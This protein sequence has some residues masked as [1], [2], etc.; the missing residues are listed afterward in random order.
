MPKIN[1][2]GMMVQ[3]TDQ[4]DH[5]IH[6]YVKQTDNTAHQPEVY[7]DRTGLF[8]EELERGNVSLKLTKVRVTDAG[9]YKCSVTS[10]TWPSDAFIKFQVIGIG[11]PPLVSLAAPHGG[12]R[13]TCVSGGWYPCPVL[14]WLDENGADLTNS[15]QTTQENDT[16]N[17]FTVI[18]HLDISSHSGYHACILRPS[19]ANTQ[20]ESKIQVSG[21]C[22][23]IPSIKKVIEPSAY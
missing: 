13:F 7:R 5:E 10:M 17:L 3:W 16:N 18:S 6:N 23:T 9:T 19:G 2:V 8:K 12:I 4:A 20:L 22:I 21:K 14:L 11:N 15:A 1:A